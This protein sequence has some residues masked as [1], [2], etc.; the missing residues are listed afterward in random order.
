M[1]ATAAGVIYDENERGRTNIVPTLFHE[2]LQVH[3]VQSTQPHSSR[4]DNRDLLDSINGQFH[5]NIF[6]SDQAQLQTDDDVQ[7][8]TYALSMEKPY[9]NRRQNHHI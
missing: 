2:K 1:T 5:K 9:L 6:Y 7:I 8:D 3:E 4:I